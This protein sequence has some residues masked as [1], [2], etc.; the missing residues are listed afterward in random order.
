MIDLAR[1]MQNAISTIE[2]H[3]SSGEQILWSGQPRKGIV[4]RRTDG[5]V[6]PFSVLWCGFA[7][8]WEFMATRGLSKSQ[9][10][11][12]VIFPLFGV[13]FVLVG[14]YFVFGRFLVDA[15]ARAQTFYAITN[16]RVL[17]V[18]G[19]FSRRVKSINLATLTDVSM[20]ERNDGTGT[21]TFGPTAMWGQWFPIGSW[22][23]AGQYA[24]PAFDVID[25][26]KEVYDLIRKAQKAAVLT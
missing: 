21:I 16:E 19:L 1:A 6:I 3:L 22:P 2:K 4:F 7:I 23:G 20:T 11:I 24:T 13:P 12:S 25:R 8:F 14:L 9:G 5:F 15:R 26:A 18:S 17:I 10:P